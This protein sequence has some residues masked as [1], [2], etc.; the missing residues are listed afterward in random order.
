MHITNFSWSCRRSKQSFS[1]TKAE[2]YIVELDLPSSLLFCRVSV[3]HSIFHYWLQ[4][5]R[6]NRRRRMLMFRLWLISLQKDLVS[7]I[8]TIYNVIGIFIVTVWETVAAPAN[9]ICLS[10]PLL[11]LI[12]PLLW[13]GFWWHLMEVL[14]LNQLINQNFIKISLEITT[15]LVNVNS[16]SKYLTWALRPFTN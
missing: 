5:R 15:V 10:V 16:K 9:S 1:F 14:E 2:T 4:M 7:R 6:L 13:F 8:L 11:R 3:G 12:S